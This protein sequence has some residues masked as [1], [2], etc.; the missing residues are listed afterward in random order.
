MEN[1]NNE[2]LEISQKL[3]P[4]PTP[5]PLR[6][7]LAIIA[8]VGL[9]LL[10]GTF[11]TMGMLMLAGIDMQSLINGAVDT[12]LDG[13]NRQLLRLSLM[14][15]H[16]F[17]FVIAGIIAF[18]L[19]YANRWKEALQ[20]DR[21]F[22]LNMLLVGIAALGL[23]LP[24]IQWLYEWN[25][26]WPLPAWMKASEAATEKLI[27]T[28]LI[29]KNPAEVILNILVIAIVPAIGEEII[30]RGG[31]QKQLGRLIQNPHI[32]IWLTAA[33]FSAF[34][35]QFEG[36]LPRMVLGVLLGYTY[37]WS[38]SLWLPIALHAIN[39][40]SQVLLAASL[41]DEMKSVENEMVTLPWYQWAVVLTSLT[42]CLFLLWKWRVPKST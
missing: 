32:A 23:S 13:T 18:R 39:N 38:R 29:T 5:A 35:M 1:Q 34:H 27:E 26:T 24:I 41:G 2:V 11:V 16:L 9:G 20:L 28:L 31:L 36:F 33:L 21:G 30:F 19:M 12:K 15:S 25:K 8:L 4:R 40:G 7:L 6:V 22:P 14:A 42:A 3:D 17:G 37:Y 10:I